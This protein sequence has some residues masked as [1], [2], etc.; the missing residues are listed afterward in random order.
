MRPIHSARLSAGIIFGLVV[1]LAPLSIATAGEPPTGA[2]L[3]VRLVDKP[4]PVVEGNDVAYVARVRNLGPDT[5]TNVELDEYL[6]AGT[7]LVS[8]RGDGFDCGGITVLGKGADVVC[9]S[10]AIAPDDVASATFVVETSPLSEGSTT[11]TDFVHLF[12]DNDPN[13]DNN[14]RHEDTLVVERNADHTSGYIPPE[15]GV[16]S[17]DVGPPGPDASDTTVLRM[18]VA[19]GGPGGRAALDEEECHP[20]FA[21]CIDKIGDFRPPPGYTTDVARIIAV[22]LI[23]ASKDPGV[24]KREVQVGYRKRSSDPVVNLPRCRDD[25]AAPC[26]LQVKRIV[27]QGWLRVRI[28]TESDPKFNPR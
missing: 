9:T 19:G 14:S 10:P 28:L 24:P 3:R 15:G 16:L 2:D 20:P 17:T 26:I 6:P 4:D 11:I 8:S 1:A 21:P 25:A 7:T 12:A 18:R 5:A 13:P 22:F 23:D 27:A